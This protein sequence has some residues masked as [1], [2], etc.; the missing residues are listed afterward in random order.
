MTRVP[1]DQPARR[2]PVECP[3]EAWLTFLGHR[4]NAL[5]LWHL[6]G[7][8]KRHGELAALL[9]DIAPK[10]LAE[11]LS[12]L[13]ERRL[14]RRSPVATFPR[15]VTYALSPAGKE[16]VSILDRLEIWSRRND[17]SESRS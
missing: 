12:G 5:V 16:L 13:E 9:P 14:I 15:R 2:R 4:W 8:A 6:Q 11:R 3:V 17:Q 10:V 7:G 1:L